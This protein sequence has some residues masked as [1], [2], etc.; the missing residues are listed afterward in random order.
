MKDTNADSPI[1]DDEI[2]HHSLTEL[3]CENLQ[4]NGLQGIVRGGSS[5]APLESFLLQRLWSIEE[6]KE[7]PDVAICRLRANAGNGR[8]QQVVWQVESATH[9]A[10]ILEASAVHVQ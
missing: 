9:P 4:D 5:V 2:F 10:I 6:P 7:S 1:L 8:S 3:D